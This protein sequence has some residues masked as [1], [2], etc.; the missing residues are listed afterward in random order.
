[1]KLDH[2]WLERSFG[3]RVALNSIPK[4]NVIEIKSE[5]VFAKFHLSSERAPYATSLE[6][7]GVKFD[8]DLVGAI[9]GEPPLCPTLGPRSR[10]R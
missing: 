7:F 8:R 4:D 9:E 6:E 3:R 10:R 1:M 5:Q 2:Q